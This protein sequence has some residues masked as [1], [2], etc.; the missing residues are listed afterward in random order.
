M[1]IRNEKDTNDHETAYNGGYTQQSI[2][3][4]RV[5]SNG[6]HPEVTNYLEYS[7][8]CDGESD[9]RFRFEGP[10]SE[11][12]NQRVLRSHD[13]LIFVIA[14]IRC[15]VDTARS[16]GDGGQVHWKDETQQ[17]NLIGSSSNVVSVPG[18]EMYEQMVITSTLK[19]S[20]NSVPVAQR[21]V[22]NKQ[23]KDRPDLSSC[24][25]WNMRIWIS[26]KC[27]VICIDIFL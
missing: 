12:N 1:R 15:V 14:S 7:T 4:C 13:G 27:L 17:N 21:D 24:R 6:T 9:P 26:L 16:R 19:E 22:I 3:I 5:I 2:S 10:T 11:M 25:H 23:H 18:P 8:D 20:D